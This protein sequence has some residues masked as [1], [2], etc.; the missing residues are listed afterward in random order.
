MQASF[1]CFARGL[2]GDGGHPAAPACLWGLPW[3][4][5]PVEPQPEDGEGLTQFTALSGTT[6]PDLSLVGL[7]LEVEGLE[8]GSQS[9]S[10]LKEE[11]SKE[12]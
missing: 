6:D 9:L 10:S 8:E 1:S 4:L 5:V 11:F 7:I 12:T 2:S 3:S